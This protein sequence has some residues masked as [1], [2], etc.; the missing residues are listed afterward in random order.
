[1]TRQSVSLCVNNPYTWC[2]P[3]LEDLVLP[4]QAVEVFGSRIPESILSVFDL[5]FAQIQLLQKLNRLENAYLSVAILMKT[6]K[7]AITTF[8]FG[9]I[10]VYLRKSYDHE[11]QRR[12]VKI[13]DPNLIA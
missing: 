9:Y 2:V 1:M 5:P 11:L 6:Y 10:G 12:V 4:L 7:L 8:T 13:Y 3:S